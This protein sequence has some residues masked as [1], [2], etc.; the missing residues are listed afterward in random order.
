MIDSVAGDMAVLKELPESV[1][2]GLGCV[3]VRFSEIDTPEKIVERV[4]NSLK[5]TDDVYLAR[6]YAAAL[7]IFRGRVWRA[8]IDRKLSSRAQR[9]DVESLPR[10]KPR[11]GPC[12]FPVQH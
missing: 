6:I 9:R 4:E 10:A 2:I 1:R 8:G 3:D 5:V 12:H 11:G 7:E